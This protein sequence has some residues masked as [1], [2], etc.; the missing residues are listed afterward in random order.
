MSVSNE[1]GKSSSLMRLATTNCL[2]S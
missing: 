2:L 1:S